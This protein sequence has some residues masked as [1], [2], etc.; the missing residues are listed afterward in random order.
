MPTGLIA[1]LRQ[2][3]HKNA[4]ALRVHRHPAK[5]AGTR[6]VLGHRERFVGHVLGQACGFIVAG[7]HERVCNW[8]VTLLLSALGSCNTAVKSGQG[9]Q[10]TDQ[11]HAARPDF[12][13][14]QMEGKHDAV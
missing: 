7:G 14:P 1:G 6:V 10:E 13:A 8:E 11:A 5:T 2:L 3:C 12:D 4:M 9:E